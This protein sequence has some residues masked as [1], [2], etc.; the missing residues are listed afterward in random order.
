MQL[1]AD[2]HLHSRFADAVSP[3]MTVFSI[4]TWAQYKGIDLLGT[5]DCLQ[6][7]WLREIEQTMEPAESG[8][9]R[10][11]PEMVAAVVQELP[12]RLYRPLRFVLSTEVCCAPAGTPLLGGLHHLIYFPSVESV[13]RF[14][15]L[16]ERTGDLRA[17]R[18]TLNLNSRELLEIVLKQDEA[19]QLAP[20]HV[21]NPWYSALGTVSGHRSLDEVFGDLT[22]LLLG[23]ELGLTSIPPMCRRMSTLD[24]HA[25]FCGSDAH[26]LGNIG[27]EHMLLDIEPSYSGLFAALRSG[28]KGLVRGMVKFP[29]E[30][31]RYFPN[32]CGVCHQ[33]DFGERCPCCHR[34]LV[35]GSRDRLETIADRDQP[36]EQAGAAPFQQLLP[37]AYVLAEL[38][39]V[40]RKGK[41][42]IHHKA[43][44]IEAIGSERY[45]LTEATQEEIAEA[46]TPQL[47]RSIVA[48][49]ITPPRAK[50]KS[51]TDLNDD[52]LP[53]G[54]A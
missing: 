53:L 11:R 4:A 17:G 49:R 42:A 40:D 23:A 32:W 48:Q 12:P 30:R 9:L 46:S 3:Q 51:R 33:S 29:V 37:L 54:L 35:P 52:Q 27:R 6:K 25:L 36:M 10:L 41:I 39:N 15:S 19:V 8:L 44:L 13:R 14:Q 16:V 5:G 2:L 28:D 24:Q 43:R 50:P 1:A 26:S 22:P 34:R 31:A 38:M 45:I 47:A 7:D 18:P 21:L 20:A